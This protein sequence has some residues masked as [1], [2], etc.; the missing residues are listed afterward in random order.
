MVLLSH[1]VSVYE[2]IVFGCVQIDIAFRH[3]FCD[4]IVTAG[5]GAIKKNKLHISAIFL[6][7]YAFY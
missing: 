5:R 3:L 7:T 1:Q 2:F 6:F 4:S